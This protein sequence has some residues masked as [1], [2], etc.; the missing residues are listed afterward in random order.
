MNSLHVN[1]ASG[2][3]PLSIPHSEACSRVGP[4]ANQ[5]IRQLIP[6]RR[7]GHPGH[8]SVDRLSD[9]RMRGHDIVAPSG[10]S[11]AQLFGRSDRALFN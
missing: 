9:S 5:L 10:T 11:V 1:G 6:N 7:I 4:L 8:H 3:L 2:S